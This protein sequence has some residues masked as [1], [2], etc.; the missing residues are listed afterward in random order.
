MFKAY[1]KNFI[2][3]NFSVPENVVK[4]KFYFSSSLIKKATQWF[5]I[6]GRF[7]SQCQLEKSFISFESTFNFYES[8]LNSIDLDPNFT[9]LQRQSKTSEQ[10][11]PGFVSDV[12]AHLGALPNPLPG[13]LIWIKLE[14]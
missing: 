10:F 5:W 3:F 12:A 13:D 2:M 8:N 4:R 1:N 6:R 9:F 7:F 14:V 11:F